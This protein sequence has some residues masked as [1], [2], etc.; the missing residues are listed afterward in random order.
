MTGPTI[1]AIAGKPV[2]PANLHV[3]AA[4]LGVVPGH[5]VADLVAVG[6]RVEH[7]AV[8]LAFQRLEY[9]P[10][11]RVV[12][13]VTARVP[14]AGRQIVDWLWTE[15]EALGYEREQRPWHPHLTL[16]RHARLAPAPNF[17]PPLPVGAANGAATGWQLALVESSTHPEGVRYRP[18]A[19]WP[20]KGDATL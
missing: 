7:P 2:Q 11:P 20:L 1:A 14:P 12:V 15:L 16:V 13:A 19:T 3:T 10:K 9:W 5:G 17:G 6:G 18:L 8:E 4:F